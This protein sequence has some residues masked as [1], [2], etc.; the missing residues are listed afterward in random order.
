MRWKL[1]KGGTCCFIDL[2]QDYAIGLEGENLNYIKLKSK[3]EDL[4]IN[5]IEDLSVAHFIS[6]MQLGLEQLFAEEVIGLK[7]KFLGLTIEGVIP[8]ENHTLNWT[9]KQQNKYY[10]IMEKVD[11]EVLLQYHYSYDCMRKRD[12]Y[13]ISKSKY[14]ILCT[15]NISNI[16][17]ISKYARSL[18]KI[19]L[20][21]DAE[22]ADISPRIKI[23]K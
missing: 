6:G 15:N 18:G 19:V 8:Y 23:Y 7:E 11:K 5:L 16:D 10:S 17:P 22:S 12:K 20:T 9:E 3:I 13:M 1:K 21:M 2:L 4:C 14:V